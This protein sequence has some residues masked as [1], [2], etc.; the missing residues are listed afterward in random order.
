M[1]VG[2]AGDRLTLDCQEFA[3][4]YALLTRSTFSSTFNGAAHDVGALLNEDTTLI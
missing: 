4:R 1:I 3:A 2:W